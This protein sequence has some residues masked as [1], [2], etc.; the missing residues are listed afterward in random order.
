MDII[1]GRWLKIDKVLNNLKETRNNPHKTNQ[2]NKKQKEENN[3]NKKERKT[4]CLKLPAHRMR[5]SPIGI[6]KQ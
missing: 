6:P 2:K 4:P 5:T 1:Q 3:K